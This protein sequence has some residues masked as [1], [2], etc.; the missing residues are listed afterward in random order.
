MNGR[1]RGDSLARPTSHGKSGVSVVDYAVWSLLSRRRKGKGIGRK[2]KRGGLGREGKGRLLPFPF[3]L[4][5]AFLPPRLPL[6]FLRL[7]H[8]LCNM[9]PR[10]IF[11]SIANSLLKEPSNLTDHS[12]IMTWLNINTVNNHLATEKTN[13]TLICLPKKENDSS[14]KFKTALQTRHTQRLMHDFLVDCRPD[15]HINS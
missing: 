2:K 9:R 3:P 15:K 5:R 1:F 4:F 7:T 8:R 6:P 14:K 10:L 11:H 13:D 12:P